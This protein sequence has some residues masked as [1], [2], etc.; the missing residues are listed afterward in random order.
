MTRGRSLP[1]RFTT[2]VLKWW[3]DKLLAKRSCR[4]DLIYAPHLVCVT[5]VR[6]TTIRL[7]PWVS[8]H[9]VAT[10]SE[11]IP[12]EKTSAAEAQTQL[13]IHVAVVHHLVIL[14][15]AKSI[16]FLPHMLGFFPTSVLGEYTIVPHVV[17]GINSNWKKMGDKYLSFFVPST[18]LVHRLFTKRRI[19]LPLFSKKYC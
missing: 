11:K 19:S 14:I 17:E 6:L 15:P 8:S 5:M 9:I 18:E 12:S 3:K 7:S 10:T 2:E 13:S 4:V 1:Q 16:H